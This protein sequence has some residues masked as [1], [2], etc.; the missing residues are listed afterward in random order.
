M[1]KVTLITGAARG[2]GLAT[3]KIFSRIGYRVLMLD[4]DRPALIEATSKLSESYPLV[5]DVSDPKL[6]EELVEKVR[7][8]F[9]QLDCLINNAGVA[10]FNPIE[11]TSHQA[12]R[13]IMSTNLDGPFYLSQAL[14]PL[15]K[16]TRGTIVNIASISGLRGST[17]RVAY[18]TSKAALI[19][20]TKQQA[21]E[22]GEYGIRVNAVA[23]GPVRTK[24]AM[25]VHTQ[26]IINTYHDHIP[27]NRYGTEDELGE[28]IYFLC[29]EKASYITGQVIS[30]DGGFDAT[31]VGLPALRT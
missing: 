18:G 4:R 1:K 8:E 5:F 12:W 2:I 15:L 26:E 23:P 28:V 10:T 7:D 13:E 27:L 16:K 30:V 22:L 29:S 19:Q 31:G 14:T 21:V 9:G 11:K 24:L 20:L 17:L 3:A 25:A 6:G